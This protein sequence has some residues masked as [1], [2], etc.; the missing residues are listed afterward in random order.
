MRTDKL[1]RVLSKCVAPLVA[2]A[3]W[4]LSSQST[5]PEI[6]GVFGVD[7]VQHLLA[8]A[9]LAVG[10]AFWFPRARWRERATLTFVAVA[11]ITSIYGATDEVHQ[12]FVPG[13]SCDVWD[14][15]ADTAGAAL[16]AALYTKILKLYFKS[17]TLN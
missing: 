13:R 3:I 10:V 15:V 4:A 11:C 2:G 17:S 1:I 16:G 9:V 6:K 7:K 8:Y 14:W 5:L 12:H